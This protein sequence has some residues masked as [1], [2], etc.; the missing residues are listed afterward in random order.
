MRTAVGVELAEH[1][2]EEQERRTAVQ[3]RQQVELGQ[4]EG[5]DRRP[6]LAPRGEAGQVPDRPVV[7]QLEREV[8]TV[9]PD[10]G[11][12]VPDLLVGRLD[13]PAG[14]GRPNG[15]ARPGRGVRFVAQAQAALLGGHL[16]M[17]RRQRLRDRGEDRQPGGDH[18]SARVEHR[19]VP[20]AELIAT[21]LL[22]ADRPKQAVSLLEGAT[23]GG[24][25]G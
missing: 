11:R 9:R 7:V 1:V 16:A 2:V 15:L 20:V 24:Q 17:G 8:V 25:V 21:G 4:L 18:G 6:L 3:A 23:V 12:A 13:E 19:G 5:Q 14:E 10:Q 22:F